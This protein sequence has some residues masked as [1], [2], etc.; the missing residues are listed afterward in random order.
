[1]NS[2]LNKKSLEEDRTRASDASGS[3]QMRQS[4]NRSTGKF[5]K[6]VVDPLIS[7]QDNCTEILPVFVK[8][9]VDYSSKFGL[10]FLLSDG[11]TGVCFNDKTVLF[12]NQEGDRTSICEHKKRREVII[13]EIKPKDLTESF[14]K[15]FG[16]FSHFKEYMRNS[17]KSETSRLEMASSSNE[18]HYVARW[19]KTK[20]AMIFRLSNKFIQLRF[21]DATELFIDTFRRSLVYIDKAGTIVNLKMS[22]V[23]SMGSIELQKR[24]KYAK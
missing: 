8:K 21:K 17:D 1:M 6:S 16:L 12:Q 19:K 22:E 20:Y 3:E 5:T 10:G 4:G 14:C 9:W 23:N 7:K 11:T 24:Y 18:Q 2:Q 13:T 15:K